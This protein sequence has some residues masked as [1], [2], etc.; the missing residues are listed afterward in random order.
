MKLNYGNRK[1]M[2]KLQVYEKTDEYLEDSRI[3]LLSYM[4]M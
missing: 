3:T 1:E 4:K 2:I